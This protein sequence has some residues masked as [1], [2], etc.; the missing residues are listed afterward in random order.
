MQVSTF[1]NI[2]LGGLA[3]KAFDSFCGFVRLFV[4]SAVML[5]FVFVFCFLVPA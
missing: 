4:A 2:F 5:W 1:V 3:G